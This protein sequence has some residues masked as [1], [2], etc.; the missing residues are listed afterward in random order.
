MPVST[1]D[2]TVPYAIEAE[3][4]A[5]GCLLLD[6]RRACPIVF[7]LPEAAFYQ[8]KHRMI[9]AAIKRL[10][11][12][13][14]DIDLTTV[15][16][17][18]AATGELEAIGS[19]VYIAELVQTVASS[20]NVRSYVAIIRRTWKQRQMLDVASSVAQ[21]AYACP[22]ESAVNTAISRHINLL[23]ELEIGAANGNE[24][25]RGAYAV[26]E[27]ALYYQEHP[28]QPGEVRGIDTGYPDLNLATGGL[29]RGNVYYLLAVEHSGK[30]FMC[31]NLLN[32]ICQNGGRAVMFSLEMS[33][34]TSSTGYQEATLWER[35][36]LMNARVDVQRY[37]A[38]VLTRE[39]QERMATAANTLSTYNFTIYDDL[40]RLDDIVATVYQEQQRREIDLC[41]I[42]YLKLIALDRSQRTDSPNVNLSIVT[43]ALKSLARESTVPLFVPHQVSSKAI[44]QRSNKRPLLSD[45]YFTGDLGQDAD[46][47]LSW[48]REDLYWSI[49][50]QQANRDR[51]GVP[52]E[53][54]VLKD[55]PSGGTKNFVELFFEK[56]GRLQPLVRPSNYDQVDPNERIFG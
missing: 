37:R 7:A 30:T 32:N 19:I 55:R 2:T 15:Q 36:V 11:D 3:E 20:A 33:A 10:Y 48:Y 8:A 22:D 40:S 6:P 49:E 25:A 27:K 46:V 39:E 24:A 52:V 12:Q 54:H 17:Q 41:C 38:G 4:N 1:P 34:S 43:S 9:Y 47:V 31:L 23:R 26:L 5:L 42:D 50:E 21:A 29:L 28:L 14:M 56:T 45:G 35:L 18:L 44:A 16:E 13:S 51:R 53:V